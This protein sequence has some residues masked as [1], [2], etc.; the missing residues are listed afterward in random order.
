MTSI[1]P[2]VTKESIFISVLG[3][4]YLH[5]SLLLET[6]DLNFLSLWFSHNLDES[7]LK[8]AFDNLFCSS[9]YNKLRPQHNSLMFEFFDKIRYAKFI[10]HKLTFLSPLQR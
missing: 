9:K 6:S 8:L 10:Y 5:V 7:K 1:K 3:T 4:N 2:I